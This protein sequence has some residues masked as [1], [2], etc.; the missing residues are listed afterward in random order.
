[1][2]PSVGGIRPS[3]TQ[4]C[5]FAFELSMWRRHIA[6]FAHSSGDAQTG[7]DEAHQHEPG[8]ENAER[9]KQLLGDSCPIHEFTLRGAG[10]AEIVP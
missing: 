3:F 9:E 7:Q 10:T 6:P 1:M 8:G 4:M 2:V 5:V